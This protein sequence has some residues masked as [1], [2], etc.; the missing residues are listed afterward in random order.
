MDFINDDFRKQNSLRIINHP[1]STSL[2]VVKGDNPFRSLQERIMKWAFA[3]ERGVKNIPEGAWKGE[4]FEIDTDDSEFAGAIK[5]DNPKY[6][7][8][9]L[10]EHLKDNK[11]VWITDYGI[12]EKSRKKY[13]LDFV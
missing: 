6:W 10:R 3:P 5:I 9:R 7:A 12:A 8:F 1:I 4:T 13:S 2:L 11:R